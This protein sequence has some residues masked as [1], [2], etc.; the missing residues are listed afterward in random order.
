MTGF[1]RISTLAIVATAT[2]QLALP[3]IADAQQAYSGVKQQRRPTMSQNI[4]PQ[5]ILSEP[6]GGAR[7]ASDHPG[8][9]DR[10]YG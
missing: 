7:R 10:W 2:L 4:G 6:G 9:H 3:S 1:V 5:R 8:R